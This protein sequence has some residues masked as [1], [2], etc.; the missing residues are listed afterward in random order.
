[1]PFLV[2]I[3]GKKLVNWEG[4]RKISGKNLDRG[5]LERKNSCPKTENLFSLSISNS[6]K[7]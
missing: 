3:H 2:N 1:M 4:E 6:P 5:N 7:S